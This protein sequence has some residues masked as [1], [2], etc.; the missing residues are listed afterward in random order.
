[1]VDEPEGFFA[2][3]CCRKSI[4]SFGGSFHF[5]FLNLYVSLVHCV[6]C[7]VSTASSL[8]V[9]RLDVLSINNSLLKW[10]LRDNDLWER[11]LS[12]ASVWHSVCGCFKWVSSTDMNRDWAAL[13]SFK[14]VY[15]YFSYGIFPM[16]FFLEYL[17][18][19]YCSDVSY[20]CCLKVVSFYSYDILESC[21]MMLVTSWCI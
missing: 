19:R 21:Y 16:V 15:F 11:I 14:L 4:G 17:T 2:W 5:F 8:A 6:Y 12:L 3:Y 7:E 9:A 18:T 1:M 20:K 13:L 10:C